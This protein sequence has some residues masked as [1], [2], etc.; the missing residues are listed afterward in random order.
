MEGLQYNTA[1][2][3]L[4]IP[5]YGRNVKNMIEFAKTVADRDERNQV[6]KAII[7]VMGQLNPHLRDVEDFTHKLWDHLFII[8]NFELDVDS[9]YPKPDIKAAK[10]KPELLSYSKE[11][12]RF[13]Y[14]GK[15]VS[16]FIKEAIEMEEGDKK[17]ALI[18]EIVNLM[19]RSFLIWNKDHVD[20]DV[21]INHLDILSKGKLEL[22]DESK[23]KSVDQLGISQF[24]NKKN[25]SHNNNKHRNNKHRNN[26]NN[27]HRNKKRN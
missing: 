13:A 15:S 3:E 19:K 5:E 27:N 20:N 1:R 17:E 10:E 16:F 23:I 8:S 7:S 12:I 4:T 6:A 25:H 9:P 24:K 14:Y 18:S 11:R 21:I 2:E 26:R 22:K